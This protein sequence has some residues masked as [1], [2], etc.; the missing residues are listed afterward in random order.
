[1]MSKR[2]WGVCPNC[3]YYDETSIGTWGC[4]ACPVCGEWTELKWDPPEDVKEEG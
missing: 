3:G 2:V 4:Q 1:M